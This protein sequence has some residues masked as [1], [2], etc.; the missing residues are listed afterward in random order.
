MIP[1]KEPLP[2]SQAQVLTGMGPLNISNRHG[3]S[4]TS[5]E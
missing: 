1:A 2:H 3:S 5:W 4:S